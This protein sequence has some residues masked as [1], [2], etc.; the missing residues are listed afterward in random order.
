MIPKIKKIQSIKAIQMWTYK[1]SNNVIKYIYD[2]GQNISGYVQI[3]FEFIEKL[4]TNQTLTLRFSEVKMH[5]PYGPV[6]GSL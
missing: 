5:P 4:N 6:D 2:F 1:D 3:N